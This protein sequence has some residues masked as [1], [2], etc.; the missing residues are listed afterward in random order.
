MH[1]EIEHLQVNHSNSILSNA[2]I[3]VSCHDLQC[4]TDASFASNMPGL[5]VSGA[6]APLDKAH[7]LGVDASQLFPGIRFL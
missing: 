3:C 7:S 1:A 4:T 5:G 2:I 6:M